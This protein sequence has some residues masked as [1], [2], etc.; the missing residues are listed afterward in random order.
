M[1]VIDL[2][3]SPVVY[4]LVRSPRTRRITIRVTAEGVAVTAPARVSVAGVER[5][6]RADRDWITA[7][8]ARAVAAAPPP[9]TDGTVLPFLDEELLLTVADVRGPRREGARL[10]VPVGTDPVAAV[11]RWYRAR[12]RDHLGALVGAWAPVMGVAPTGLAVRGQ[13]SR[14][15]SASARGTIALNWRLMLAPSRIGEYVVVHELAH[16]LHMDHSPR[17]WAAVERHWPGH[18]ADRAW[19]RSNGPSVLAMIRGP[20]PGSVVSAG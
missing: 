2:N 1:A 19:L 7:A 18:R 11:E 10:L 14:W 12:A 16:L 13:R 9:L 8:L 15:G 3:G 17:F 6:L 4:R 5:A 20:V